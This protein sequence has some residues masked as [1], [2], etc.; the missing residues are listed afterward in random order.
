[1]NE[2]RDRTVVI[3]DD[4]GPVTDATLA[5][6]LYSKRVE[7]KDPHESNEAARMLRY[8]ERINRAVVAGCDQRGQIPEVVA[9]LL[10]E[11]VDAEVEATVKLVVEESRR[12]RVAYQNGLIAELGRAISR[13][14]NAR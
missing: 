13:F 11:I 5:V 6:A 7:S 9:G 4:P 1:M 8:A 10:L 2:F 12:D 14:G 3:R